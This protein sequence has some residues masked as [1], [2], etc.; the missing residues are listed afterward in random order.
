MYGL[1]RLRLPKQFRSEVKTVEVRTSSRRSEFSS[2]DLLERFDEVQRT[3]E[4]PVYHRTGPM[5][6]MANAK[7]LDVQGSLMLLAIEDDIWAVLDMTKTET[8]MLSILRK[9]PVSSLAFCLDDKVVG[10]IGS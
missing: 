9:Y 4:Y 6:F 8:P 7:M 3:V 10:E 2:R 5:R 1:G